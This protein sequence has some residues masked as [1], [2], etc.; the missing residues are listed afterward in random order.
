MRKLRD[1]YVMRIRDQEDIG[2]FA[3]RIQDNKHITVMPSK[4]KIT[5]VGEMTIRRFK[6]GRACF[7][8]GYIAGVDASYKAIPTGDYLLISS[9]HF[10]ELKQL[11][12]SGQM[13]ENLTLMSGDGGSITWGNGLTLY[14]KPDGIWLH[15][16]PA[17][18]MTTINK[19][20]GLSFEFTRGIYAPDD[21][22]IIETVTLS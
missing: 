14:V 12:W 11:T 9:D 21:E 10:D 5:N 4:H 17:A 8:R 6:I 1:R 18:T 16:T 20:V 13:A 22:K 3:G 2:D 7:Y 15:V 19:D